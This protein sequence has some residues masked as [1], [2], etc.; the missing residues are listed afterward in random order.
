MGG[1]YDFMPPTPALLHGVAELSS[2][3]I[4]EEYGATAGEG[5]HPRTVRH[6]HA[7]M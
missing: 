4:Q 7:G 6:P 1:E 5:R 2:T 3:C